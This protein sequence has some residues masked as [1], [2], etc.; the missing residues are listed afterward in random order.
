MSPDTLARA[1]RPGRL[2]GLTLR[3]RVIK[4]ATYE[5]MSPSGVAS[6]ALVHHHQRLAKGGV[7]MTTVAYCAVSAE[8]RT[9]GDQLQLSEASLPVL[10]RLT[11]A[12]HAEG[13]AA[14]LQLGHCGGF[15]KLGRPRGPSRVL[16]RY[17]AASGRLW[18]TPMDE[19]DLTRTIDAFAS[20]AHTARDLGFDAVELHLGHGY[21]LSQFLSPLTNRRRDRWGGPLENRMR[22]PLA[23]VDAVRAR[24]GAD[25]PI[26]AKVNLRD[27]CAGGLTL[28]ES[29]VL[30]QHLE[31]RGVDALVLSGG[32]VSHN[33]FY[34]LRGES[35]A[36]A[37]AAVEPNWLQKS[38]IALLGP[39]MLRSPPFTEL[40]F[41]ED[42]CQV[43]EAV[44]MPL[45]LLGGVVSSQNVAKAMEAGFDYVAA[46]RALL[47]DPDWAQKVLRD[48][49][50]H[51]RCTHCNLC[52]AEMDRDGVRCVL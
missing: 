18:V 41:Y 31:A 39:L 52:I 10:R 26:V 51:S 20:S 49:E 21:L 40:F 46:G 29:V 4:S 19:G 5:G 16:N 17:G 25:F 8:G 6:D 14:S 9:F 12:V 38:A 22:L 3:N 28:E 45:V 44:E 47:A 15:S 35:P 43:R 32:L 1:G 23:V 50:A 27:G 24:V 13:A 30:A 33:A 42:A 34:L 11:A 36:R 48:G 7:G 37:M 2:A